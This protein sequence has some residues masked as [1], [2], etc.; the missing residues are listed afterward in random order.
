MGVAGVEAAPLDQVGHGQAAAGERADG[1]DRPVRSE[2]RQDGMEALA[3]GQARVHPG[4]GVVHPQPERRDDPLD[5]GAQL[6]L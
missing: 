2:R 3:A 6:A 4:T 1:H 5:Q